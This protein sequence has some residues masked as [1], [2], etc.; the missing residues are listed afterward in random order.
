[1]GGMR[2]VVLVLTCAFLAACPA[3]LKIYVHNNSD[4]TIHVESLRAQNKVTAIRAGR[5]KTIQNG[6]LDNVCFE[7]SVGGD[8]RIYSIDPNSGPYIHSTAYG[9]RL[10]FYFVDDAM[11]IR[12]S[13]GE[14]LEIF[15]QEQCVE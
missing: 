5:A 15:V 14:R 10:D 7:L 9:G 11:Y 4:N 13:T 12:S 6:S 8:V 2:V 1:M 3:Y